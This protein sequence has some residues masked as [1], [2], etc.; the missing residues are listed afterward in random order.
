MMGYPS[1]QHLP[2]AE[3]TVSSPGPVWGYVTPQPCS[4]VSDTATALPLDLGQLGKDGAEGAASGNV[5]P[6]DCK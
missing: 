4:P 3:V 6:L 2:G 5:C 1:R